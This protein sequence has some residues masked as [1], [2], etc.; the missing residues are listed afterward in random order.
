MKT[1]QEDYEAARTEDD[2]AEDEPQEEWMKKYTY[3]RQTH[4]PSPPKA[5]GPIEME[6]PI[7][8]A[9]NVAVSAETKPTWSNVAATA[10]GWYQNGSV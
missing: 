9:S 8:G 10:E 3:N 6:M 5:G 1:R 4:V 7:V 2:T